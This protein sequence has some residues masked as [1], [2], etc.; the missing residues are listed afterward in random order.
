MPSTF[1]Q[2]FS[3]Q[4]LFDRVT[5]HVRASDTLSERVKVCLETRESCASKDD[6]IL[7]PA[8]DSVLKT[9]PLCHPL[10]VSEWG[11]RQEKVLLLL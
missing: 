5:K 10:V 6:A 11:Y 4:L 8:F 3:D 2:F 9:Q 1:C 7:C